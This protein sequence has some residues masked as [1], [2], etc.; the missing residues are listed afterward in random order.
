VPRES[1]KSKAE[2]G[3]DSYHGGLGETAGSTEIFWMTPE[4]TEIAAPF[5]GSGHIRKR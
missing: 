4:V 3:E 5:G 2:M 1:Q